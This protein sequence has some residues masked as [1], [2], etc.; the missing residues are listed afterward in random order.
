MLRSWVTYFFRWRYGIEEGKL[1]SIF[2]V[3]SITSAL[4]M[5]VASSLAKRF[6]NIKVR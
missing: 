6:G 4:S 3:T 1:G 5:L 2:F